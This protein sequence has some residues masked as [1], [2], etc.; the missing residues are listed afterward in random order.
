MKAK[1]TAVAF[2][3]RSKVCSCIFHH[4]PASNNKKQTAT[5]SFREG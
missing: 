5:F 4:P 2:K 3:M 1:K